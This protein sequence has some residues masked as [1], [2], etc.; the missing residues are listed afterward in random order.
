MRMKEYGVLKT[1]KKSK[2]QQDLSELAEEDILILDEEDNNIDCYYVFVYVGILMVKNRVIKCCPKYFIGNE[3]ENKEEWETNLRLI[4]RVLQK[5]QSKNQEVQLY[6][7]YNEHSYNQLGAMVFFINDFYNNGIYKNSEEIIEVNGTGEPVWDRIINETYAVIQDDQPIYTELITRR[8]VD[9]KD[10]FI[11]KLHECLVTECTRKLEK[12]GLLNLL[13]IEGAY[14]VDKTF[15]DLG[16][17]DYFLY[18]LERELQVQFNT[19]KQQLLLAMISFFDQRGIWDT[20]EKL[21]L[22]GTSNFN[23]IWEEVCASGFDNYLHK[24]IKDIS[25][26]IIPSSIDPALDDEELISV[27]EHPKWYGIDFNGEEFE[28]EAQS[29]LRPDLAY[30]YNNKCRHEFVIFDAKYYC[31]SLVSDQTL[32]GQPGVEDITKQYLY[33]IAFREFMQARGISTVKNAFLIPSYDNQ[34]RKFG[35]ASLPFMER[36]LHL[37]RIVVISVGANDM[38][39]LYIND[40][41][42]INME[43]IFSICS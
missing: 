39:D 24:K 8:R 5:Y 42:V 10:D 27:I 2:K 21:N 28:K 33:Q 16:D 13:N 38:Y 36:L 41:Q 3:M 30:I 26:P 17:Y 40:N 29:T 4:L 20:T 34:I 12:A 19:R 14:L 18:K 22:Y 31:V 25:F 6:L 1:V 35:Y 11:R 15:D 43:S 7:D 37:N 23:L 32:K 9:N